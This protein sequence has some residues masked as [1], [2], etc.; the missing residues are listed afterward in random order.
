M[1]VMVRVRHTTFYST[2][3]FG[4]E[5]VRGLV[6]VPL[7]PHHHAARGTVRG[8]G[9]RTAV[10]PV[11]LRCVRARPPPHGETDVRGSCHGTQRS[12]APCTGLRERRAQR[13]GL[14][15]IASSEWS[16]ETPVGWTATRLPAARSRLTAS[17]HR[18]P[19]HRVGRLSKAA[20]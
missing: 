14:R 11:V 1:T 7:G 9:A 13:S 5:G 3:A 6:G 4:Q 20:M 17:K 18:K 19:Y 15:R 10:P 2:L 8:A 12:S 16:V